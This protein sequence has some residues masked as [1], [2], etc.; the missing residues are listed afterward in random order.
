LSLSKPRKRGKKDM[1]NYRNLG[2]RGRKE[3]QGLIGI[4]W[5]LGERGKRRTHKLERWLHEEKGKA[6]PCK[7]GGKNNERTRQK[8]KR[9]ILCERLLNARPHHLGVEKE[10]GI[11]N[12]KTEK[13]KKNGSGQ[14]ER[15]G[16]ESPPGMLMEGSC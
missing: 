10:C 15:R 14:G 16:G 4:Q 2:T 3:P 13:E 9:T 7:R 11:G 12:P 8:Q 1:R 5:S 6:E